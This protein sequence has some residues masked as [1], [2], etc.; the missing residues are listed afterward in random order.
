V[1]RPELGKMCILGGEVR[2]DVILAILSLGGFRASMFLL[3]RESEREIEE[4]EDDLDTD[5]VSLLLLR[6]LVRPLM[7]NSRSLSRFCVSL[8]LIFE[9]ILQISSDPVI[10][11]D[12]FSPVIVSTRSFMN[13]ECW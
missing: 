3:L 12:I 1:L 10:G 11:M 5:V 9:R 7:I 2:G 4:R 13:A 6:R 8:A